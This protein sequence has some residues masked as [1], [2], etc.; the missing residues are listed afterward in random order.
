[1]PLLSI[2]SLC[3][4]MLSTTS[5]HT[6]EQDQNEHQKNT[7]ASTS[8]SLRGYLYAKESPTKSLHPKKFDALEK[9][10][11][12]LDVA[13]K[14][15]KLI[16]SSYQTF[17]NIEQKI[18]QFEQDLDAA[19]KH[20]LSQ[21]IEEQKTIEAAYQKSKIEL[22]EKLTKL[23]AKEFDEEQKKFKDNIESTYTQNIKALTDQQAHISQTLKT[24]HAK[25]EH[26]ISNFHAVFTKAAQ[27]AEDKALQHLQEKEH[28]HDATFFDPI[29]NTEHHE[30]HCKPITTVNYLLSFFYNNH[31]CVYADAKQMKF[32]Q[33][34][35]HNGTIDPACLKNIAP[36]VAEAAQFIA[37]YKILKKIEDGKPFIIK[38][39]TCIAVKKDL[40]CRNRSSEQIRS[41]DQIEKKDSDDQIEKKAAVSAFPQH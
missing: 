40:R 25:Y 7:A 17:Q 9:E 41:D 26:S 22:Q 2:L 34:L 29:A 8:Y 37:K 6:Q 33:C 1:M 31:G 27:R 36:Q 39:C 32:S 21:N 14:D 3:V 35:E 13:L 11:D 4:V 30:T 24:L 10:I 18:E 19:Y 38:Y 20:H 23:S 5:I 28:Q 16:E 12:T 15:D